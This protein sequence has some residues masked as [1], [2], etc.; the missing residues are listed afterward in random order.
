[1]KAA[2]AGD[3]EKASKPDQVEA[4]EVT[5]SRLKN[6]DV[7]A[8]VVVITKEEITA[9]GVTSIEDLIRTLPQNVA[10]IGAITNERGRGPLSNRTAAVSQIGSLGVSAAN[11][12]GMGA[13]NTLVLVNGRRVA[14]AAGIEDGFANLNGIPLS[15]V[16]RV[17]IT[18]DG[19]SAVYGSDAM[20]GV[21]N[22]ILKKNYVGTTLTA[23]HQDSSNDANTD[24]VS[25]YS[26]YAWGSGSI[27]G[28]L[29][30]SRRMPVNNYKS[31]YFTED[32]SSYYG[33]NA[34]YDT[35]SFTRGLQPGV[36]DRSY[37]TYDPVTFQTIRVREGLTV[38]KGFV[39]APGIN[40]FITVGAESLPDYVPELAGPKSE[41]ASATINFE[42]KITDKLSVFANGLYS[43]SRS[44]QDIK[45]ATGLTVQLAPGQ[46]Y[47]PFPAYY[48]DSWTPGVSV[49]YNP[50][51]EV[52]K[53]DLPQGR[54]TNISKSWNFNTG[55][56]YRF[57]DDTKLEM[58]YT[59]S[60]SDASGQ[61]PTLASTVS[62]ISDPTKPNGVACYNFML[63][64]NRLKGAA[65]DNLQAAFDRQCLALTSSDPTKAFNP[66]KSS[67][68]G[69][70]TSVADFYYFQD[71]ENRN[72]R[73]QNFETR[74]NGV[75][76]NLP[77][78][79]LYYVVGAEYA[80]DGVDSAEVRQLSAE[81]VSRDRYAWFGE[82]TIPVF[83]KDFSFPMARSLVVNLAARRDTY[84]TYGAVGTVGGVSIDQGGEL[85]YDKSTFARTTP[86]VG[87]R[88]EP[89]EGLA[90]R[91]K[92]TKGFKAPPFSQLFN[93][94]GTQTYSSI[95][96][97]DPL[98]RCTTDCYYGA[99]SATNAYAVP[100][101]T[102][103]NPDL[104]PQTS[105]QR[106]YGVS[107][108]PKGVLEGL[109]F[110]V[111]YN[112]TRIENEFARPRDLQSLMSAA[113]ILKLEQFYPRDPTTGKILRSQNQIFNI[114]GSDYASITYEASYL[115]ITPYGTF[116]P[117][118]TYLDN[119]KAERRAFASAPAVSSLGYLQGPDDYKIQAS[120]G[121][122]Y[123]DL[124]AQLWAYYT[125]SYLNDYDVYMA[126]GRVLDTS[127]YKPVDSMTT[128]D[129]TASWRVN[130]QLRMNF[131]GR[132]IF[133]T[134]PP[135]VVVGGRP[136]DTA[137][138]NAEGRT[139]SLELQYAF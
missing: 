129:L 23:Q 51:D 46:A 115:W 105:S 36:I 130:N 47:N 66:W 103:P 2:P 86:A 29:D 70:G 126:A 97:N 3:A 120:L 18:T 138:Y 67:A 65:R 73:L 6:G 114:L 5:G 121:W 25:L 135:F 139:L 26:G 35:R 106:S 60:Q 76:F 75:A 21:I 54:I 24:R 63:A 31:G 82:L 30:Y 62:F 17:E 74:L 37:S 16:E 118:V 22:F 83:G 111:N 125:P 68:A 88:W 124:S 123:H 102:A 57:N 131:A 64:Q 55:L 109:S 80:D 15:A 27:S 42:Q 90:F 127:F 104:K 107:W 19:G 58:M 93:V 61:S 133:D 99:N 28:T 69:G 94:S 39:G 92:F 38:P 45:Y 52:A 95:I 1:M 81:A 98:Y 116:E 84:K 53:G 91:G 78:G 137:R 134:K 87:V 132:N 43:R 59:T 12:G 20:G 10:T 48:F 101:T 110:D 77:G 117:K 72:S 44:A 108:R 113:D 14:G 100:L 89:V 13:G 112:R 56:T 41:A 7:T 40:D 128:I 49:S 122:Y 79:K 8:R 85:I 11:L 50:A 71:I 136:Y 33:G 34:T 32:Y 96:F 119:L 9:R 4:V